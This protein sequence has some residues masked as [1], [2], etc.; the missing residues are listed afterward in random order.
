MGIL[1]LSADSFFTGSRVESSEM[2]ESRAERMLRDGAEILDLGALSSRPGSAEISVADEISLLIPGLKKLRDEFPRILISVDVFRPEVA[3]AALEEG[4]DT[5]NHIQGTRICDRMLEIIADAGAAC[6]LMHSRG[7]F[8][9]MHQNTDYPE[10]LSSVASELAF[11]IH[12]AR[13]AGVKDVVAD[14]GFGFSKNPDQN[15]ALFRGMNYLQQMLSCPLLAGIS[16]KSM[17]YKKLNCSAEEALNGTTALHMA[18]L[19]QGVHILRVH[20]VKEAAETI[21]LFQ[22]LCLQES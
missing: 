13:Q 2:L 4:A 20:D 1:N 8:S 6:I 10:M 3:K 12:R 19:M 16:R 11:A 14:P 9:E 18:A 7:S 15:Y 17:I 5:I 22:E 21:Q